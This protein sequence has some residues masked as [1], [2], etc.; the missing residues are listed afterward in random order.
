MK[1]SNQTKANTLIWIYLNQNT[2]FQR[3]DVLQ[4]LESCFVCMPGGKIAL[5]KSGLLM[6]SRANSPIWDTYTFLE[7]HG[8]FVDIT[9]TNRDSIVFRHGT[10]PI[11]N[12]ISTIVFQNLK[13]LYDKNNKVVNRYEIL[14]GL[15]HVAK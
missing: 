6:L 5:T 8:Y 12:P 3:K 14:K 13:T 7:K 11:D 10:L 1:L 9:P 4:A 2:K 15:K